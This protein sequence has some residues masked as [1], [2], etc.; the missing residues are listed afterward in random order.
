MYLFMIY[1]GIISVLVGLFIPLIG[2]PIVTKREA[3]FGDSLSHVSLAGVAFGLLIGINPLYG[4]IISCVLAALIIEFLRKSLPSYQELSIA[5]VM[6][7]G[8][9]LS[10]F[11]SS[12]LKNAVTFDSFLYGSLVTITFDEFLVI[13]ISLVVTILCYIPIARD[14]YLISLN[15]EFARVNGVKVNMVNGVFSVITAVV[16]AISSKIVGSLIVASMLVIPVATAMQ[17][18]KSYRFTLFSSSLIGLSTSLVGF[19][20]SDLFNTKPGGTI[21]LLSVVVLLV[22]IVIKKILL[23]KAIHF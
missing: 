18:S 19:Y 9:G 11:L 15:E 21:I 12:F 6:A 20:L 14:L 13:I 4:A 2:L 8:I 22:V 16:V 7:L 5:I 1:G 10:G 3:M 17:F 23:K